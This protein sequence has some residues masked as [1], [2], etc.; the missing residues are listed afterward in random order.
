MAVPLAPF[1][2]PL[3]ARRIPFHQSRRVGANNRLPAADY[4]RSQ[5]GHKNNHRH[6]RP[7]VSLL[8]ANRRMTKQGTRRPPAWPTTEDLFRSAGRCGATDT[9]RWPGNAGRPCLRSR[10][11]WEVS[12]SDTREISSRWC[13]ALIIRGFSHAASLPNWAGYARCEMRSAHLGASSRLLDVPLPLHTDL[14]LT[15]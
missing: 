12:P 13:Q 5:N 15:R 7:A 11:R 8:R 10:C 6:R 9:K 1:L 14:E 4:D 3:S 2:P